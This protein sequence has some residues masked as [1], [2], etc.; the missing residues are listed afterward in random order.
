MSLHT[1]KESK[2]IK[3][4][5]IENCEDILAFLNYKKDNSMVRNRSIYEGK[6]ITFEIDEYLEP[7]KA[8][9]VSFEGD[10]TTCD[11]V[12]KQFTE[13]NKKYKI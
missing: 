6:N 12:N 3:Y 1:R 2:K 4:D 13:L 9:V 10:K 7:E 5:S 8:Y 11:K